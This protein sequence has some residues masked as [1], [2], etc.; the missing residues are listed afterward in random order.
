[1]K[2]SKGLV[3]IS[4]ASR[5]IGRAI[6]LALAEAA[7]VNHG[8]ESSSSSILSSHH[9]HMVLVARSAPLLQETADML[10]QRCGDNDSI[11]TTTCLEMD[12]ADIDSLPQNVT[13]ILEPLANE[14]YNSCLLINNAGSL[15]PL[16]K[17]T[18]ICDEESPSVSLRRWRDTIDFNITSS[19]WISSQFAKATSHISLVRVINISSLCASEPF[20]TMSLYCAGKA[21]R[22]MFHAVLAK[23]QISQSHEEKE[24]TTTTTSNPTQFKVLNYAPGACNTAMTDVL[25]ESTDLDNE[26]QQYFSTSRDKHQL[27]RPDDT[28]AKLVGLLMKDEFESG[29]HVD[30][31]DV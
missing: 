6:A 5:G 21:A 27:V 20:P 4:G 2:S 8:K 16:G 30:Y 9:L 3:V 10:Q 22:D 14:N 23:E 31:W 26:L 7:C 18:S 19:L 17:A 1:M 11:I 15:G 12:L 24:G 29:T 28:A 25:A 13:K